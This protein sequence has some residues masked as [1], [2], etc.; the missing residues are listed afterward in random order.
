MSWIESILPALRDTDQALA[1]LKALAGET[2]DDTIV[3]I[4]IF[5]VARRRAFLERE[6]G[7]VL[8]RR[9]TDLIEVRFEAEGGA[10]AAATGVFASIAAFQALLT[11]TYASLPGEADGPA[12]ERFAPPFAGA[13]NIRAGFTLAFL[14]AR[15]LAPPSRTE[16]ALENA[17][18][19]LTA[20]GEP[21][22]RALVGEVGLRGVAAARQWAHV[23]TENRFG[24]SIRWQKSGTVDRVVQIPA[25]RAEV[26]RTTIDGIRDH[27]VETIVTDGEL[28]GFD[29]ITGVFRLE[30]A[31][32]LLAGRLAP[33]FVGAGA[34]RLRT[35]YSATLSLTATVD[36][37][38]ALRD[39]AFELH[40]LVPKGGS[41]AIPR[42]R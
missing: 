13:T 39:E 12:E 18:A 26:L 9:Q 2:P 38:T 29:P 36:Y 27:T 21:R 10:P 20:R 16:M 17:L 5:A 3:G 1:E 32:G 14:N 28:L 24:V 25:S 31:T 8:H 6:L 11:E 40:T 15:L 30:T 7:Q 41:G 4:N 33:D 19:L 35:R 22:I 37:A 34:V 42:P 23:S